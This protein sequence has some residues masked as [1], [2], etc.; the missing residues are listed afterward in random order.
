MTKDKKENIEETQE[1]ELDQTE[2]DS[3]EAQ[4][5]HFLEIYI[6]QMKEVIKAAN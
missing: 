1:V 6:N 2:R 5:T 4:I 3:R